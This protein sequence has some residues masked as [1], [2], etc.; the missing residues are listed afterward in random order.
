MTATAASEN[1][2]T[3]LEFAE[4]ADV[5][6][7]AVIV[8]AGFSG[9]R[10]LIEMRRLGLTAIVIEEAPDVGGTWY[11][12]RYPGART[13]SQA[14]VYGFQFDELWNKWEWPEKF[15][16]QPQ[17]HGY[18]RLLTDKFD[19]WPDI[20]FETRVDSAIF[21][22]DKQTWQVSTDKGQEL[23]ARFFI[24]A[25][26]Q[27]S[28]TYFP[29]FDG[30]SEFE[31]EWYMTQNWPEGGVDFEGKRVAIVGTG[32]TAVQVIPI[33]AEEAD[34][35]TVFQRTPNYV[36]P[37]RNDALSEHD[38]K[39]IRKNGDEIFGRA[40]SQGFGMDIP[41]SAGRVAADCTPEEQQQ[42][43]ERGWEYGGFRFLFETFD[44]MLTSSETNELA[45]EFV[46]NKI[47]AIVR[48]PETAELLC[49]KNHPIGG[50]RPPLGH[51]YYETF[52]K[53]NVSLVAVPETPP[54]R[55][56]ANG[57]RVGDELHEVDAIIFATGY[58]AITGT[59]NQIDIRGRS[60]SVLRD[61]W[62]EGPRTH[63]S[64]LVN[65]FPNF[66]MI[67][68]PQS[69]FANIPVVTEYCVGWVSD[70]LTEMH[71]RSAN[72]V[73]TT[74]DAVEGFTQLTEDVTDATVVRQ[75]TAR[76]WYLGTNIPGKASATVM[77]LGGVGSFRETCDAEVSGG[78]KNLVFSSSVDGSVSR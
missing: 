20:K 69:P 59:L 9:L 10:T 44:D 13:D 15:A 27:L 56:E 67:A 75:G 58:D 60:G 34:H 23:S 1:T 72:V 25:T 35:L 46:R 43:L 74:S 3:K 64:M 36:M 57:I 47:R 28:R 70:L 38:V 11:W 2:K 6:V 76:A 7:D 33:V 61:R 66:F 8:G 16:T 49:P 19:L 65:E 12:N 50:K 18:L 55:I 54:L 48:D 62:T 68:G 51:Y 26:G 14:W 71:E 17:T 37:A 24:T 39:T 5:D 45:A 32:A 53:E 40:F 52:N 77:W 21:D 30:L 22:E 31:G 63:L 41:P 4:R 73:E 78:Y 29:D 42:I